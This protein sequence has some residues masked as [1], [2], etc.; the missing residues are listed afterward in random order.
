M[1]T[2]LI[3][4][5]V[6]NCITIFLCIFIMF[7][8]IVSLYYY[9]V[10]GSDL[11]NGS[12]GL[13]FYYILVMLFGKRR[14]YTQYHAERYVEVDLLAFYHVTGVK[15]TAQSGASFDAAVFVSKDG[16]GWRALS[17]SPV[18]HSSGDVIPVDKVT[19]HIRSVSTLDK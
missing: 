16:I 3:E 17:S 14:P 7:L 2:F 5:V 4:F 8:I 11:F 10:L 12:Y 19:S 13:L 6:F 15:V 1:L 9:Y 18:T